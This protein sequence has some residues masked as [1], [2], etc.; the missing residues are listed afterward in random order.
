MEPLL[1]LR[2]RHALHEATQIAA[3]DAGLGKWN[4]RYK[5]ECEPP[6]CPANRMPGIVLATGADIGDLAEQLGIGS[7]TDNQHVSASCHDEKMSRL[8]ESVDG[9]F[10]AA[11]SR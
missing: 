11:A 4:D 6:A 9:S 8:D 1:R 2:I 3:R 5:K 7:G 10:P